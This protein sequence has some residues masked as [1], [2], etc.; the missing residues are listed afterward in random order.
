MLRMGHYLIVAHTTHLSWAKFFWF[1]T[2]MGRDNAIMESESLDNTLLYKL[3]GIH[4]VYG[5][6]RW[7]H[8]F[9]LNKVLSDFNKS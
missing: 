8:P 2:S 9:E 3:T 1:G 5:T 4:A 6:H 7:T